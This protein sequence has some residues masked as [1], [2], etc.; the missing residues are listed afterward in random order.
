MFFDGLFQLGNTGLLHMVLLRYSVELT[1]KRNNPETLYNNQ[2]KQCQAR[3]GQKFFDA[4]KGVPALPQ[5]F[6][7]QREFRCR[8]CLVAAETAAG[9]ANYIVGEFFSYRQGRHDLSLQKL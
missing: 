1:G 5:Y 6:F 9:Q 8:R 2:N 3:A 4:Q 7:L